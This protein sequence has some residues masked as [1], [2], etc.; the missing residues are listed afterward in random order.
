MPLNIKGKRMEL[1]IVFFVKSEKLKFETKK[2]K[3][4]FFHRGK[5]VVKCVNNEKLIIIEYEWIVAQ[6]SASHFAVRL[7]SS[8]NRRSMGDKFNLNVSFMFYATYS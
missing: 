3:E 1:E 7:F 5:S 2:I 6:I 4:K 8:F